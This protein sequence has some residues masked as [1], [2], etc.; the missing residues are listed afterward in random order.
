MPLQSIAEMMILVSDNSAADS[1]RS[2]LGYRALR[3]AAA[4]GGW[5]MPDVRMFGGE[6]LLRY[7]PEYCPPRGAR[8]WCAARRETRC[9]T[10]SRTTR[11]SAPRC[12][13]RRRETALRRSGHGVVGSDRPGQRR[14]IVRLAPRNRREPRSSGCPRAPGPRRAGRGQAARKLRWE[15]RL[16]TPAI[17]V[18]AGQAARRGARRDGFTTISGR[19]PRPDWSSRTAAAATGSSRAPRFPHWCC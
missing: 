18:A 3:A 12:S 16:T 13:P 4:R 14:A 11:R 1:L 2:L 10:G 17:P 19:S 9:R 6:T 5:R 8:S 7:F 15:V